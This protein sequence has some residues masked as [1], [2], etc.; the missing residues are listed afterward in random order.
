MICKYLLS[1]GSLFIWWSVAS[2]EQSFS[3]RHSPTCLLLLFVA[4]V[5][6]PKPPKNHSKTNAKGLAPYFLLSFMVSGLMLKSLFHLDQFLGVGH[7]VSGVVP[8][9]PS[10]T[11]RA[12]CPFPIASPW[13][14]CGKLMCVGLFQG[15]IWHHWSVCLFLCQCHSVLIVTAL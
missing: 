12:D 14:L 10:T 8:T 11:H 13:L 5:F 2:T 7:T 4:F 6:V 1:C 9:F 3:I 15:C